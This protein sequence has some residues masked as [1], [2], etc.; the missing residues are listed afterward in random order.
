MGV[1][2]QGKSIHG[3]THSVVDVRA[4]DESFFSSVGPMLDG[5]NITRLSSTLLSFAVNS[6]WTATT[7]VDIFRGHGG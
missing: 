2:N 7:Y 5:N 4:N 1:S 3:A 6:D